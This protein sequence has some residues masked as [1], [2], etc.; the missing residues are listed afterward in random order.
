MR[1]RC[2]QTVTPHFCTWR[3]FKFPHSEEADR[4]S[5]AVTNAPY[6]DRSQ[7]ASSNIPKPFSL[8]PSHVDWPAPM[9]KNKS[10]TAVQQASNRLRPTPLTHTLPRA[11]C[12]NHDAALL[13]QLAVPSYQFQAL[14]TPTSRSFSTFAHATCLLS[15]SL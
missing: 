12:L 9:I 14:L 11:P 6:T 3:T 8:L 5:R 2:R 10:R 13:C 1:P 4:F 7:C 15:V